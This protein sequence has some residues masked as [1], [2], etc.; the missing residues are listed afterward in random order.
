MHR[1][2]ITLPFS[3]GRH[4]DVVTA[5]WIRSDAPK[6][7]GFEFMDIEDPSPGDNY[8]VRAEQL[9]GGIAWSSPVWVGQTSND[10]DSGVASQ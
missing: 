10:N 8:Y 4:P 3:D 5:R 1:G 2:T 7:Q 6:D 9:D